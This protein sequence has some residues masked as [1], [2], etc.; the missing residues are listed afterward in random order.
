MWYYIHIWDKRLISIYSFPFTNRTVINLLTVVSIC[1]AS[2]EKFSELNLQDRHM[3]IMIFLLCTSCKKIMK[4]QPEH[5]SWIIGRNKS[6]C[7]QLQHQP[8][9][10]DVTQGDILMLRI[11]TMT[12]ASSASEVL[13]TYLRITSSKQFIDVFSLNTIRYRI[14][15][16]FYI[17]KISSR[18]Q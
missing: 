10:P 12:G 18:T 9:L 8:N 1:M 14:T 2:N 5:A 4:K 13:S 17:W 6:Y 7:T 11:W 16:L 15:F 3:H